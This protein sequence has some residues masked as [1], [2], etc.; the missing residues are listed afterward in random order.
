MHLA[1]HAAAKTAAAGAA[2]TAVVSSGG[3]SGLSAIGTP[4]G[5]VGVAFVRMILLVVSTE[6]ECLVALHA[7]KVSILEHHW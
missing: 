5:L 4:L 3:T 7:G 6:Y 1:P 2:T